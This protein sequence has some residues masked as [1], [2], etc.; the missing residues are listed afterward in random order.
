MKITIELPTRDWKQYRGQGITG[1]VCK[2]QGKFKIE[3]EVMELPGEYIL[4]D[5]MCPFELTDPLI[6]KTVV[7]D[8]GRDHFMVRIICLDD[9]VLVE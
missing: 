5:P 9:D 8:L 7:G 4:F 6:G 3:L 1:K 2:L